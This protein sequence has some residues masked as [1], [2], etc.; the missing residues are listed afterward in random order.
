MFIDQTMLMTFYWL[1]LWRDLNNVSRQLSIRLFCFT[2]SWSLYF[3]KVHKFTEGIYYPLYLSHINIF[4]EHCQKQSSF[5]YHHDMVRD[6]LYDIFRFFWM[7][8]NLAE[9]GTCEL[10][11]SFKGVRSSLDR[12]MFYLQ[13]ECMKTNVYWFY[14]SFPASRFW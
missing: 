8:E 11:Y 13:M 14:R 7:L 2:D 3:K 6:M 12:L 1:L 5:K 9:R 10:P 4:G